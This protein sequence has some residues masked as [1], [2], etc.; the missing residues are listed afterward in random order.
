MK[1]VSAAKYAQAERRLKPARAYGGG[2]IDVYDKTGAR[3]SRRCHQ[4]AYHRYLF[5]QRSLRRYP[6]WYQQSHQRLHGQ[7]TRECGDEN[8]PRRGQVHRRHQEGRP[9]QHRNPGQGLRQEAALLRRRLRR[10]PSHL[11][12][13]IRVR[14]GN[15]ALQQV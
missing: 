10:C 3:G 6:L 4:T 13:R 11:G 2:C 14:Q 9:R 5:R 15:L 8:V 7:H 12:V 1:M